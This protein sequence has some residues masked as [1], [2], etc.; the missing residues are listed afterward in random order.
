MAAYPGVEPGVYGRRRL[1]AGQKIGE[2]TL[3]SEAGGTNALS[4]KWLI[5]CRCGKEQKR[6][7]NQL[8]YSGSISC[9]CVG[10]ERRKRTSE[11][12]RAAL[13]G[14]TFGWLTVTEIIAP[15]DGKGGGYARFRASCSCGASTPKEGVLSNLL[16]G[17][18]STCCRPACTSAESDAL[19]L[20]VLRQLSNG[21]RHYTVQHRIVARLMA[22]GLFDA[23]RWRVTAE[24]REAIRSGVLPVGV[25]RGV[26][27]P[28][29]SG[30]AGLRAKRRTSDVHE[31]R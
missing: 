7:E 16:R 15:G 25:G 11:A 23:A 29:A 31:R 2:F 24:G 21:A 10:K 27:E 4:W 19:R 6:L 22:M 1:S 30:G 3:V 20:G 8:I 5:R 18:V 28:L 12:T 26:R 9:G 17:M 13:I 14:K